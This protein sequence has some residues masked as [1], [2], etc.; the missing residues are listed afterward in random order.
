MNSFALLL[1]AC[2]LTSQQLLAQTAPV[3]IDFNLRTPA[4]ADGFNADVVIT[5]NSDIAITGWTVAFDLPVAGFSNSWNATEGASTAT[6]KVFSNISTNAKINPG[7]SRSFGFTAIGAFSVPATNFTFNDLAP[8]ANIPALSIA[9][10]SAPEGNTSNERVFNVSLSSVANTAVTVDWATEDVTALA[11]Q[12]YTTASGSLTFAAGELTKNIAVTILG[13]AQEEPNETFHIVLNNANGA[14]I[15]KATAIGT[16][17]NDD[18]A[19]GLSITGG[20]VIEGDPGNNLDLTF[21]VT[22]S[23]PAENPVSV[24]YAS[25][26]GT[27]TSGTDF[28]PVSGILLFNPGETTK[29]IT[30]PIIGDSDQE[31]PETLTITLTNPTGGSTIRTAQAI[32]SIYDNDGSGSGG[33][34]QT[35][36]YN[37]AEVLQKSLQFYDAQRSGKLPDDFRIPWRGHSALTDGSDVDLNLT[38]GFYDAGDHV[39]FGLPMAYSLTM[40]AWGG[41]EYPDAYLETGQQNHLLG[42]LKWGADYLLKCHVRN[43]DGST[44]AFYGQ[45]GEGNADHAYW[46]RAESMQMARP[47]YKIDAENPGSDLAAETAAALAATSMLLQSTEPAYAEQLLDHAE[48]LYAFADAHRGKYSDSI[49]QAANFYNSWSGFQDEL[50]WG[51][52]WLYRATG[53]AAYLTKAALE[54]DSLSGGGAGNHSYQWSLSWDDKSYA[55]YVLMAQ[56]DGGASYRADAERWLDYWT[57][58]VNGQKVSTTPGGLAWR[59]QWGTLRY[60]ANTAFCAGVYADHVNDPENRYSDFARSQIEYALGSNPAGRSYVCGFGNNPPVNPHHR[61]S[62]A[63]VTND[64]NTPANNRH[65]LSGALVGGP[66]I[67]DTYIDDRTDYVQNEVAMDYNAGFT[68]ALARL[69]QNYGGY[70]LG[71]TITPP[72]PI[73]LLHESMDD[74]PTGAKTDIEWKALWLGTKWANGSDEGRLSVDENIAYGGNGKAVRVLYPQGGQQSGGSGAQ[75]FIDLD[76]EYQ[77]LYFSYWVRFENDFDFVL[78]G[79]LP[80][81]GG[82]N[83]FDDRTNEWS[84]R[85]MWREQGKAEFYLHAPAEND[86]DPGTRFWWNTEGFQATFVPGRW[87]H[88]EMRYRLNTPGQFDGLMEGWFDGVKAASYPAFYFRDAPTSGAQIAWVFFSTFF[89]GSSSDIWQANKDEYATFDEFTVSNQRIGYPGIPH[90]VDADH[91]PNIWE[92]EFFGNDTSAVSSQ[93]SDGDGNNNLDEFIAGTDPINAADSFSATVMPLSDGMIGIR[94]NGKAG[95]IYRLHHSTDL[96]IWKVVDETG[97]LEIDQQIDFLRPSESPGSFFRVSVTRP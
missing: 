63:S 7:A 76:G 50:T 9:D 65:V 86:Y 72:I 8:A 42:V 24:D 21:T 97:T 78:G 25:S 17:V 38:G 27:A 35:G 83:S 96:S 69:Y 26:S 31:F 43:P 57:I 92:L 75:W 71:E 18:F 47:A 61:N 6:R 10:H 54:Y 29:T 62:H 80:G 2:L 90:D 30:T 95:H 41:V 4:W 87:H 1:A 56:L 3:S 19:P 89:G 37:F 64:I 81:L 77:E 16:L 36:N 58:G 67:T 5:N 40:L 59:D 55:C 68:G 14:P 51:A 66:D 46:G 44:A 94:A 93:D 33:K 60:A 85:L 70:T 23:P 13:D 22:L 11:D 45:V 39:K 82:G 52:I 91:L 32:G 20:S 48:A 73:T 49:P 84:G 28:T 53:N 12:D 15:N 34:P 88:I 74:F 79:K